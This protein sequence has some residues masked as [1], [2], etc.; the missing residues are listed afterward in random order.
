MHQFDAPDP[1]YS[2]IFD[3]FFFLTFPAFF[4]NP[5]I[6]SNLNTNWSNLLDMRNLQEQVKKAFC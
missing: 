3:R 4:L 2:I 1:V 6:F 5:N